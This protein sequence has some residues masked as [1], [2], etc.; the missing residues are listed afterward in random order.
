VIVSQE[1]SHGLLSASYVEEGG[2]LRRWRINRWLAPF[3]S[4][5]AA[6]SDPRGGRCFVPVDDSHVMVFQYLFHPERPLTEAEVR[7]L[8]P[9]SPEKKEYTPAL[10]R[11]AYPLPNGYVVDTWRD[12]RNLGND[13][14]E[15]RRLQQ[16]TNMSGIPAQRT[17][18]ACVV[19]RQG[20]GPIADRS[21]ELLGSSDRSI[22]AM[23]RILLRAAQELLDG[24]E[25]A[26]A[27]HPENYSVRALEAVSPH[28]DLDQVLDE[29]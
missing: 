16:T 8:Q 25:P 14:L 7:R 23:R 3:F 11:C 9:N 19:E 22:M 12:A 29:R 4:L 6:P 28:T 17:Q 15:D 27:R 24:V 20:E 5:I 26:N 1:V 13:Y 2:G 10:E 18:D 21:R